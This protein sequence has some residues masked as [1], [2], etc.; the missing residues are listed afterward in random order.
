MSLVCQ[1]D[2]NALKSVSLTSKEDEEDDNGGGD[3]D[4]DDDTR[5]LVGGCHFIEVHVA[6]IVALYD[7]VA[8]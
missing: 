6:C 1:L 8:Y 3:D 2:T 5:R 4:D 7:G